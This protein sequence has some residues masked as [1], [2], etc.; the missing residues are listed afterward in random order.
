MK[1][2]FLLCVIVFAGLSCQ[3]QSNENYLHNRYTLDR[4][5]TNSAGTQTS[6]IPLVSRPPADVIGDVYLTKHYNAS[7]F[8]LYNNDKIVEGYYSKLDLKQNEFDL[9]TPQGL[10]ALKGSLVKSFLYVDSVTHFQNNF[11]NLK[12]WTYDKGSILD[13][14]AEI[15]SEGKIILVKRTELIFKKADFNPALNVG[16][17]DH[18]YLKTPKLYYVAAGIIYELPRKKELPKIFNEREGEMRTY[19]E[20]QNLNLGSEKDMIKLFAYYNLI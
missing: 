8:Q 20:K 19:I 15:L 10:R 11:V 13:G 18:K 14:F 12:E 6:G 1:K 2:I 17:K 16:S 4:I 7:V 5:G 9:V 3:S